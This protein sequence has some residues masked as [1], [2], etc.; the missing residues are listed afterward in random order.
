M[1]KAIEKSQR[2]VQESQTKEYTTLNL[3]P[4]HPATHGIFQNVLKMDG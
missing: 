4:T 1:D 2:F 3:G